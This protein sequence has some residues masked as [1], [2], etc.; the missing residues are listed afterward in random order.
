[1]RNNWDCS[2]KPE[3]FL[4]TPRTSTIARTP[5]RSTGY[6]TCRAAPITRI[7][8][9]SRLWH[10]LPTILVNSDWKWRIPKKW[11]HQFQGLANLSSIFRCCAEAGST[12]VQWKPRGALVGTATNVW[13]ISL[14]TFNYSTRIRVCR[15]SRPRVGACGRK[16]IINTSITTA[17]GYTK[18]EKSLVYRRWWLPSL[19]SISSIGASWTPKRCSTRSERPRFLLGALLAN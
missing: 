8:L 12:T 18:S 10:Q 2:S 17:N 3:T 4:S 19:L 9:H 16:K 6:S 14:I 15:T 1:M 7:H 13:R 11:R 5:Y